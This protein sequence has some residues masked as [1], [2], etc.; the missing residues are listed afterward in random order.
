MIRNRRMSPWT[1][2]LILAL[3]ARRLQQRFAIARRCCH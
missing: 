3:I 2:L 1:S